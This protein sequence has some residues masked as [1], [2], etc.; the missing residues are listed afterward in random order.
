M[1]KTLIPAV[2]CSLILGAG[3]AQQP[4]FHPV[5]T[6]RQLMDSTVHP[7]AEIIF[8]SVGT[9]ISLEK[10]VEEIAPKND[11]E[12]A[13]VRRGA[14]TLAEAGNLLM[15]GNRPKDNDLWFRNARSLT[16]AAMV[17]VKAVDERNPEA[18]FNA[19]GQVYEV[20]KS[21]HDHY[22]GSARRDQGR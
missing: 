21:C 9:I 15:I 8:D 1:R 18:L 19:G 20:C 10:G 12:W 13:E 3:C 7:S 11:E 5:A 2:V 4:P 17:A 14:L 22:W 16:D 6:V